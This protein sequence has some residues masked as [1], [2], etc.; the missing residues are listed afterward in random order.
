MQLS[1]HKVK[2]CVEISL[3][4]HIGVGS[5]FADKEHV[6]LRKK[7][8]ELIDHHHQRVVGV[9]KLL[10]DVDYLFMEDLPEFER[11][12]TSCFFTYVLLHPLL[13]RVFLVIC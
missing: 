1:L 13:L 9:S 12:L 11:G 2:F 4:L 6:R 3:Y 10:P 8:F 5:L 7:L